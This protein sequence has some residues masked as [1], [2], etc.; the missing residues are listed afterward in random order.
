MKDVTK[1]E[2]C[3]ICKS[4]E[5]IE[6]INLGTQT[7]T[8]VFPKSENEHIVSGPLAVAWC[9][10]CDLLQLQHRYPPEEMYGENYGYRSGLNHS[11]IEHLAGKASQLSFLAEVKSGDSVL[12][13]G[14]NDGTLLSKYS[15]KNLQRVGIDPTAAKF[16]DYYEDGIELIPDFFSSK[17]L[18]G[19]KFKVITS[20]SM[21]YDLED[22]LLFVKEVKESLDEDGIWHF[23]QSYMPS[24][25]RQ[26]SYDTICHEHVEYYSLTPV[27]SMLEKAGLRIIDVKMNGVNGG[28]FAVSACHRDAYKNYHCD[29]LEWLLQREEKS[30]YSTPS[31]YR[32]FEQKI[33]EHRQSLRSLIDNINQ[34]GKIIHVYGASTKG[35][36]LLQFCGFTKE[37]LP[38][39][40]EIN[41][42]KYSRV[43]PGSH[44]PII[45]ADESRLMKPAYYLVLPWH[46]RESVIR[47]ERQFLADGGNLIFPLPEIEIF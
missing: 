31:P 41:P 23:E 37:D 7:L 42:Y 45:S 19:R 36:V 16:Q 46:F 17:K 6:V 26:N 35:N 15:N 39:A 38:Y 28:S 4:L 10:Q 13:I 34:Q 14:S 8:G 30:G 21:F 44:I 9:R 18:G 1:I 22:P 3:R 24:M 11:M 32:E 5:L 25:I 47:N 33:F 27:A 29:I 43:T 2:N 20:I 40:A 12:D